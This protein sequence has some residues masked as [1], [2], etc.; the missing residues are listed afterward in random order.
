MSYTV[1]CVNLRCDKAAYDKS[2]VYRVMLDNQVVV[3]R[4]FWPETPDYFIQEQITLDDD[5][6][7]HRVNIKNIHPERGSIYTHDF[8]F[9]DGDTKETLNIEYSALEDGQFIFKLPKR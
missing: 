9:F 7:N 8:L 5:D 1:I 6:C 4:R 3:E 2:P